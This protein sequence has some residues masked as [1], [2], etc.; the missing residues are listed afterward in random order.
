MSTYPSTNPK[1]RS[2]AIKVSLTSALHADLVAVS[3]ALG[4]TPATAASFAIGQWVAQ[5]KS[6]LSA[7][8]TAVNA[9]VDKAG[10][11]LVSIMRNLAESSK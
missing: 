11:E 1:K 9:L 3:G 2:H 5:Q 6:S 10:P 8:T 7:G 4:Q